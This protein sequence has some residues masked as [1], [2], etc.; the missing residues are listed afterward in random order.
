MQ[1]KEGRGLNDSPHYGVGSSFV[2]VERVVVNGMPTAMEIIRE[3]HKSVSAIQQG[4]LV[5]EFL[6]PDACR[7]EARKRQSQLGSDQGS[8]FKEG[9]L[10]VRCPARVHVQVGVSDSQT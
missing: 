5:F 2:V 3:V 10:R 8:K 7:E 9:K 1:E 6:H 4:G